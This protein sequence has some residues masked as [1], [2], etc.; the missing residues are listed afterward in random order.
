[1][2]SNVYKNCSTCRQDNNLFCQ[3]CK[4]SSHFLNKNLTCVDATLNSSYSAVYC[5]ESISGCHR[6]TGFFNNATCLS[7]IPGFVKQGNQCLNTTQYNCKNQDPNCQQCDP[8]NMTQCSYCNYQYY[9]DASTKKCLNCMNSILGQC[10]YCY[11]NQSTSTT[12]SLQVLTCGYCSQGYF[13]NQT[14][15]K[16]VYCKDAISG[17]S[18]CGMYNNELLC[19]DCGYSLG[20]NTNSSKCESCAAM[21]PNCS[22]CSLNWNYTNQ[23]YYSACQSCV[24]GY[25]YNYDNRN[26]LS[27]N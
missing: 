26:C 11:Y 10:Q 5:N 20:F 4:N 23:K 24:Y 19:W 1:M 15:G 8:N 9:L 13:F 16:C 17:C 6:C 18:N 7:C 14:A 2:G 3:T 12:P 21:T 22:Y 25:V 27:C